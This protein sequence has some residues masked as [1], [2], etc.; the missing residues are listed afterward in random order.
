MPQHNVFMSYSR[1]DTEI[2]QR[3]RD[4]LAAAGIS[5]WT[6]KGI[7]PGAPS[8]KVEIENAIREADCL[9]ALFSPDAAQS[10]WVRAELDFA[11]AQQ[12]RVFP[13]LVGGDAANAVPFG[14]STYQWIDIRSLLDYPERI[15]SLIAALQQ[16]IA[17]GSPQ[18]AES[19]VIPPRQAAASTPSPAKARSLTPLFVLVPLLVVIVALLALLTQGQPTGESTAQ[20]T[21][22]PLGTTRPTAAQAL[23]NPEVTADLAKVGRY[24]LRVI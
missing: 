21:L 18:S 24:K 23:A 1:R 22:T 20:V 19:E 15:A 2:M 4:D 10:R 14:F 17:H 12:K 9:V 8:W 3:I 7:P 13:V 16:Q 6:D 5:V 11:D